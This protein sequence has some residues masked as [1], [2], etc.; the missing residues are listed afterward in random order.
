MTT[1]SPGK[2]VISQMRTAQAAG[3]PTL[4][5]IPTIPAAASI[6]IVAP[7]MPPASPA[8]RRP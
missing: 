2:R 4:A 5:V 3:A 1:R 6:E 7:P 8:N